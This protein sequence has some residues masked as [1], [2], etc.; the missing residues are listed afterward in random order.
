MKLKTATIIAIIGNL[1]SFIGK[2][3]MNFGDFRWTED[4]I[5]TLKITWFL[6]YFIESGTLT[7]FL[8]V[9]FTK[10]K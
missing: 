8:S 10:Q 6:I 4:N 2:A 5:V 9:L 7:L 1:L 3:V